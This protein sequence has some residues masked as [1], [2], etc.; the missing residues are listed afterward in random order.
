MKNRMRALV[1][2]TAALAI[3][4]TACGRDENGGATGNGDSE[5]IADGAA[6]GTLNVWAMGVEGEN[7]PALADQFVAEMDGAGVD[8]AVIVPPTWTGY[9]TGYRTGRSIGRSYRS[10]YRPR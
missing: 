7:L 6:S 5:P 2:L 9:E 4:V 10:S 1:A 3:S 8:R